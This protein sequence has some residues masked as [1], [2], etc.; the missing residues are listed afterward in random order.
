MSRRVSIADARNQLTRLLREVEQGEVVQVTRHGR[1]VAALIPIAEYRRL[2]E[3]QPS[4][5]SAA[6]AFREKVGREGLKAIDGAL[7]DLR[8]RGPG[9]EVEL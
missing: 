7:E 1:P 5:A 2:R 3:G 6:A 9:R 4:L 8:D